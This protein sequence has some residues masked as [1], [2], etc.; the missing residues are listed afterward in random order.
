MLNKFLLYG[1]FQRKREE[2]FEVTIQGISIEV[3]RKRIKNLYV[4]VHRYT[5]RVRVSCPLHISDS[6]L[7][8]FIHSRSN[9]IMNQ[10]E[11]A[12]SRKP[13]IKLEYI[14]GEKVCFE[15]EEFLLEIRESIKK[16]EVRIEEDSLILYVRGSSSRK[17]REQILENWYRTKLKQRIPDLIQKYESR[18]GVEVN[19][20]GV[21]KMKT[22]WGTCNIRVRRI[23]L[24]LELAKKPKECLEMVVV[25]EMVHLLER[26]HSKLFYK[27]MDDFM[28]DWRIYNKELNSSVD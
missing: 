9:W 28:P 13:N 17:K 7:E 19:E 18:M 12:A 2:V 14:T 6:A 3:S 20:F 1:M 22:R 5:G 23:W 15:G 10:K 16:S 25:H 8:R 24:S 26:L 27:L 4:R 21:K 11:K